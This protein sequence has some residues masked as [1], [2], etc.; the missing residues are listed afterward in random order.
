M[1]CAVH[2]KNSLLMEKYFNF[3]SNL[4]GKKLL[5]LLLYRLPRQYVMHS[6]I[7]STD[8][9]YIIL[10]CSKSSNL[11]SFFLQFSFDWCCCTKKF[12]CTSQVWRMFWD[13]RNSTIFI[14]LTDICASF[15]F[16]GKN[17]AEQKIPTI[18]KLILTSIKVVRSAM[19]RSFHSTECKTISCFLKCKTF[20]VCKYAQHIICRTLQRLECLWKS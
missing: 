2:K 18:C 12:G 1:R 3:V 8:L 5:H 17:P 13:S 4:K 16:E 9:S 20:V 15:Q 6:V 14:P 7:A 11:K 10:R 19:V